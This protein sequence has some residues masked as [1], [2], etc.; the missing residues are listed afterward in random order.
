MLT[1][2]SI[3]S[4]TVADAAGQTTEA[5]EEAKPVASSTIQTIS[6][7]DPIVIAGTAGA[8]FLAYFLL[9]PV[10]SALSFSLRGYQ[11]SLTP[12]YINKELPSDRYS[13][14][15]GQGQGWHSPP[16]IEC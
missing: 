4:Q 9:P 15:E 6:S 5:V 2:R 11:G 14:R 1:E 10:W 12:A 8:L 16:T 7:A 13:T 3:W